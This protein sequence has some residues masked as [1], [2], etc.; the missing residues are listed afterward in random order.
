MRDLVE[1][2]GKVIRRRISM[3]IE[4]Y[5]DR[6]LKEIVGSTTFLSF[7]E[8]NSELYKIVRESEFV[9]PTIPAGYYTP[10]IEGYAEGLREGIRRCEI[11]SY[12]PESLAISLMGM[13]HMLG[14]AYVYFKRFSSIN[15]IATRLWSLLTSGILAEGWGGRCG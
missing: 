9:D 2:L 10:F 6:R 5:E 8:R 13:N 7:V 1:V 4:S 15:Y 14:Q 12:P 11:A 3:S